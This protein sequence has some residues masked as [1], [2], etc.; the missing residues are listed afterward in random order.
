LHDAEGRC[1]GGGAHRTYSSGAFLLNSS[2]GSKSLHCR[3]RGAPSASRAARRSCTQQAQAARGALRAEAAEGAGAHPVAVLRG[4]AV[5][6]AELADVRGLAFKR[7]VLAVVVRGAH[8]ADDVHVLHHVGEAGARR[9]HVA[10]SAAVAHALT[11]VLCA[12]RAVKVLQARRAAIFLLTADHLRGNSEFFGSRAAS[13]LLAE[14]GICRSTKHL[15][16][17]PTVLQAGA[18]C[19]CTLDSSTCQALSAVLLPALPARMALLPRSA[20]AC[21]CTRLVAGAL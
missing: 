14:A 7:A 3:T 8:V 12:Q 5:K 17:A 6:R 4:L 11:V 19:I 13:C 10:A 18:P 2:S 15:A 9:A 1:D 16:Q 21:A 20:G